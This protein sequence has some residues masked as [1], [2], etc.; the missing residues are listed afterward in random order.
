MATNQELR[1]R[2]IDAELLIDP[3]IHGEDWMRLFDAALVPDGPYNS[4]LLA[5]INGALG[6][7]YE[8]LPGAMQAY[9]ASEGDPSWDAMGT[10]EP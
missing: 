3:G 8:N 2:S 1:Q 10:F 5:W 6:T 7:S 4:R 9:A